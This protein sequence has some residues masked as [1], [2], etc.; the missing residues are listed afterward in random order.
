M[1]H[2]Y[3]LPRRLSLAAYPAFLVPK[4]LS[5]LWF[6]LPADVR[7]SCIV[8]EIAQLLVIENR[9]GGIRDE[10]IGSPQ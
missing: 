6:L 10:R 4:E 5:P 9:I 7:T 3:L 8:G 2:E 1:T